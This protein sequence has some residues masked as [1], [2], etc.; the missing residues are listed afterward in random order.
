MGDPNGPYPAPWQNLYRGMAI[1]GT[2]GFSVLPD[3]CLSMMI[4]FFFG[5]IAINMLREV[6]PERYAR[7]VPAWL[8]GSP[9]RA[10]QLPGGSASQAL[11]RCLA[12]WGHRFRT[13][14]RRWVPLPI[15]M[16]VPFLF[17][18]YIAI[19]M[20]IGAAIM[21]VWKWRSPGTVHL[22]TAGVAAGLIV[23]DGLWSIPMSVLGIAGVEAPMCASY[24]Q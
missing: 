12:R 17:G 21:A 24:Q 7:C 1:F 3:H 6:L 2:E 14:L 11:R 8:L 22:A 18:A 4:A 20:C 16:A 19:D 9:K 5:A 10:S 13:C 23:G 15:G